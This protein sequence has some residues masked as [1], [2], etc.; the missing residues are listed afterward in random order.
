MALTD[1]QLFLAYRQAKLGLQQ[2]Q[3]GVGR[4]WIARSQQGLSKTL[5][6]LGRKLNEHD[7]WFSSVPLGEVLVVPK[8]STGPK[9]PPGV[10]RIGGPAAENAVLDLRM[11]L[12]PSIQFATVEI[13]WL[14]EFGP[15]LDALTPN[16]VHSNRLRVR[17]GEID[18]FSRGPFK[19]WRED[20]TRYREQALDA[21]RF[22][23]NSGSRDCVLATL[24][25][26]DFYDNI[27]PSFLLKP[28][29]VEALTA[30]T[31]HW[32]R[33]L[34]AVRYLAATETL[35]G[36]IASYQQVAAEISGIPVAKGI[37]IG[38]LTSRVIS[39][40]ALTTLDAHV[41][42]QPGV[43]RYG[44]YVDDMLIVSRGRIGTD[45]GPTDVSARF[46]PL[47]GSGDSSDDLHLDTDKLQRTGSRFYLQERK[48]KVYSLH[49]Q[50]GL[51]FLSTIER[52]VRIIASERRAFLKPDGLG[53]D[54]PLAALV[55]GSDENVPVQVLRDA[56]RLKVGRYAASVV[57]DK[58]DVGVELLKQKEATPWSKSQLAS[59]VDTITTAEHWVEYVEYAFR[60]LGVSISARDTDTANNIVRKY[61]DHLKGL[62]SGA[63]TLQ[64]NGRPVT[65]GL[66][67]RKLNSWFE[68]R[69]AEEVSAS[70]PLEIG[71]VPDSF[72]RFA[73]E[74]GGEFLDGEHKLSPERHC[75]WVSLLF[76]A[77]LRKRDRESDIADYVGPLPKA[78]REPEDERWDY[79]LANDSAT[80]RRIGRLQD[81]LDLC[82]SI[83]DLTFSGLS[84]VDLMLMTKPPTQ[85]DIGYRWTRGERDPRRL[86]ETTNSV[87]GTNYSLTIIRQ[88]DQFTLD[89]T[90]GMPAATGVSKFHL[91]LGNLPVSE[92]W[93]VEAA[94]GR[95]VETRERLQLLAKII[96]RAVSLKA[97]HGGHT[98]L[99]LPELSVPRRWFRRLSEWLTANQISWVGG[100]EYRQ[101]PNG[102]VNEAAGVFAISTRHAAVSL[103]RKG[104]PARVELKTLL[105]ASVNYELQASSP[106]PLVVN[107]EF[108]AISTLICSELL[109]VERRAALLGRTDLLLVP[110]WNTDTSTFEHE[111][112]TAAYDLHSY[113]AV[114]NNANYSDCRIQV[115]AKDRYQR[116]V[117]RLILRGHSDSIFSTLDASSLRLF[118]KKSLLDP[119]L[120]T[121]KE[122]FMPLPPGYELKLPR[123]F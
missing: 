86:L 41:S 110:C 74:I 88:P 119:Q 9:P 33:P 97:L 46:L 120:D 94:L 5:D 114:S 83:G 35:V 71:L 65:S 81:F 92:K 72:A 117:C 115:P 32:P 43:F 18:R 89:I 106:P 53:T 100:L 58:A 66:A 103:W 12:Y 68:R 37:P 50:P 105:D 16:T 78:K 99:L 63:K 75:E 52:D 54:S 23:L 20:Y 111:V 67:S 36:S 121:K 8:K 123:L 7:D 21:A 13:L 77:D 61:R 51:D 40:L 19:Y 49:G 15:A 27:D 4:V 107:T 80:E 28:E 108:G 30:T 96:N 84:P 45:E 69:I 60:A 17:Y 6:R 118:Q 70:V 26:A 39:N 31:A 42:S 25:L 95:P 14:W 59:L 29:F 44:R 98:L 93:L 87:R 73:S 56:D 82:S 101:G 113:V 1:S 10:I 64:W 104:K 47:I 38:S 24:D 116:D 48:L 112:Q 109:D 2:E 91:L 62:F 122:Q 79:A 57:I 3:R 76:L 22:L 55:V 102:V 90:D 34:D 11:Q 85:F